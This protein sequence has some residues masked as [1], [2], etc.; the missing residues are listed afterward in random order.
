[1]RIRIE[2]LTGLAMLLAF[3]LRPVLVQAQTTTLERFEPINSRITVDTSETWTFRAPEGE[4]LSFV[5]RATS[6][7]LDPVLTITDSDSNRVISNDDYQY[8][9]SRDSLLEAITVPKTDTFTVTVSGFSST[10]GNYE[11]SMLPGYGDMVGIENFNGALN[12]TS[13]VP[14][15][16]LEPGTGQAALALEGPHQRAIAIVNSIE[17]QSDFYAQVDV[18]TVRGLNNGQFGWVVGMTA[19]QTDDDHYYLLEIDHLGQWR[20]LVRTP[21]GETILRDWVSNPSI[22]DGATEF[23]LGMMANGAG[24]DFFFDGQFF[25]QIIDSTLTEPGSIGLVI[26]TTGLVSGSVD[27]RFDDLAVNRPILINGEHVVPQ[28]LLGVNQITLVQELRRRGMIP[29]QGDTAFSVPESFVEY[30][31][32]GVSEIVLGE[33]RSF[34]NF[35]LGSSVTW[36]IRGIGPAG[37]GIL[38]HAQDDSNYTLAYLTQLGGYGVSQR[39][40]DIFEPGIFGEQLVIGD[41]PYQF[42]I[43]V[44]GET[45]YYYVNG[46]LAGSMPDSEIDGTIGSAVVNFEPLGTSCT[47]RDTWVW[48]WE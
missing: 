10:S 46:Q 25:G 47:F 41:A 16:S 14:V 17:P 34:G 3:T 9:D 11:L 29:A 22:E 8:P 38:L 35:L 20:F 33:G 26:E 42:L 24:F 7:D 43:I 1:M 5:V 37:C 21:E 18:E 13:N 30:P 40:G 27:A 28:R 4:V 31:R 19:R 32:G 36:R 2:L 48:E 39:T 6:G 12:L 45:L 23:T 15:L 44:R